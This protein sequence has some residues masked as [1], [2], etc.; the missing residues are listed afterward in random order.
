MDRSN[1]VTLTSTETGSDDLDP[2]ENA[3][4][5]I[6]D[7]RLMIHSSCRRP[8]LFWSLTQCK[9]PEHVDAS[10]LPMPCE[11]WAIRPKEQGPY[12]PFRE[13]CEVDI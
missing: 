2:P 11:T 4:E 1:K 9:V 6:A 3:P 12:T 8:W 10:V 13:A 7:A 5:S